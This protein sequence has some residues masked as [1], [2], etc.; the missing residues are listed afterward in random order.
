MDKDE[1]NQVY[2]PN[3]EF[4]PRITSQMSHENLKKYS[5][6]DVENFFNGTHYKRS[7]FGKYLG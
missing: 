3:K 1:Q 5:K 4:V 7:V 6:T 2:F